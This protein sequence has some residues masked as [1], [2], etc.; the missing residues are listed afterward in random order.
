MPSIIITG[1][2]DNSHARAFALQ[3]RIKACEL[4]TLQGAGHACNME[5]PWLWDAHLQDFLRRNNLL[6]A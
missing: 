3:E 4:V 6:D 5:Q 2:E 1:S